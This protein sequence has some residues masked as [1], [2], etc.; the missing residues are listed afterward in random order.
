MNVSELHCECQPLFI[1]KCF[2]QSV[3]HCCNYG[4]QVESHLFLT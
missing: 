1:C 4:E 2:R 3:D